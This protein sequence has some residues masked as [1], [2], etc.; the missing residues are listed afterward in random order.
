M[1]AGLTLRP[2]LS[3]TVVS[4]NHLFACAGLPTAGVPGLGQA[5]ATF[6]GSGELVVRGNVFLESGNTLEQA[7]LHEVAIDWRGEVGVRGNTVR[8]EGGGGGGVG[9]LIVTDT[10]PQDLVAKLSRVPFL[11]VDPAPKTTLDGRPVLY[12][13]P[14]SLVGTLAAVPRPEDL[15]QIGS[16]KQRFA[17]GPVLNR[18][19]TLSPEVFVPAQSASTA[20][21]RY[22]DAADVLLQ[23][24]LVDFL[25]KPIPILPRPPVK[26]RRGVQVEGNDITARGPALMVLGNG[27]AI[28]SA[29]VSGN[30]LRS[31]G[32]V[33]AVYLRRTDS[34]VF[35]GNRC[36][37]LSAVNVVVVRMERAPLTFTGNV[38][39]G[40]ETVTPPLP[41]VRPAWTLPSNSLTLQIPVGGGSTLGVPLDQELLLGGLQRRR[42]LASDAFSTLLSEIVTTP[43]IGAKA[44]G[45]TQEAAGTEVARR[46]VVDNAT[47]ED[48]RSKLP[49]GLDLRISARTLYGIAVPTDD[50]PTTALRTL[51]DR[52]A[53]YVDTPETVQ[54]HVRSVLAAAEG[55]PKKALQLV[56]KSV[57]GLDSAAPTVKQSI[58]NV[59]VLHEVLSDSFYSGTS[60]TGSKPVQEATVPI[61]PVPEPDPHAH[62]VIILGGSRVAAV[63][64]A[65]TSGVHVQE[66]DSV[67]QLNP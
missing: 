60:G 64:N 21:S 39:L 11:A 24:A 56:D 25:L 54:G 47:Q 58:L 4:D 19:L 9:V 17:V 66:A 44:E 32:G 52:V 27:G 12:T 37:C 53:L 23:P 62:S 16:L 42:D 61:L 48:V 46:A 51:V 38:V 18:S 20:A 34:T 65:T 67:V 26:A 50:S 28:I 36:Q 41:L 40:A 13:P 22:L 45:G 33:G 8:H 10:L 2:D 6:V 14:T 29:A 30:E 3:V 7:V 63:G 35:S 49:A 15:V 43:A 55:D 5:V 57:L 1:V 31:Q 59:S